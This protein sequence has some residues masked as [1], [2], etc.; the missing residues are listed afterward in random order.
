MDAPFFPCFQEPLMTELRR[1]YCSMCTR[2]QST[3]ICGWIRRTGNA[4]EVLILQHPMEVLQ[5]K[6]SAR[7]LH[8]S[9]ERSSM[10]TGEVF[11]EEKL[12]E[13]LHPPLDPSCRSILLYPPVPNMAAPSASDPDWLAS[14]SR[15]RLIVLD[16]TWR[17]SLKM[18]YRNPALQALPRLSLDRGAPSAYRIRKAQRPEQLST[19]EAT[20]H[21]LAYLE[22]NAQR[23]QPL[24][25]AF[26][27]FV[28][29][30]MSYRTLR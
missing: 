18:L 6:G 21:A 1:A 5:A 30:Q 10:E 22:Q 3:C 14:S 8:L 4:V 2:P 20:C 11:T 28:A 16:A 23:Y 17:K 19:L 24:L 26:D 29:Q 15:L 9:L 7:L 13:W 12:R 27:G 25:D